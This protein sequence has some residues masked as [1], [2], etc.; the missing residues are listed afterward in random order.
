MNRQDA[1]SAKVAPDS[2]EDTLASK[3]SQKVKKPC[4]APAEATG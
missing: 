1:K 2:R 3:K 4:G